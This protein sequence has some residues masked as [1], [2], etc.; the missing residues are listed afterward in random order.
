TPD[1]RKALMS[2]TSAAEPT[3]LLPR[4]AINTDL[5]RRILVLFLRDAVTKAGFQRAVLGLSGGLASAL[6]AYLV[7]EA[8][9]PGTVRALGMPY[10]ATPP[11]SPGGAPAGTGARR[12]TSAPVDITPVVEPPLAR[13]P[14][15]SRVRRGNTLAGMRIVLPYGQSAPT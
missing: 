3:H 13:F 5:A 15:P 1:L 8:L 7:A 12:I 4:L 6:V 9:G 11:A 14:A 2:S 10:R